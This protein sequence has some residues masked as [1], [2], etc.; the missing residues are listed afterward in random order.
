[1]MGHVSAPTDPC[2]P[3]DPSNN[4]DPCD[5]LTHDSPTHRLPWEGLL[6]YWSTH[7]NTLSITA[8]ISLQL[9]FPILE[10]QTITVTIDDSTVSVCFGFFFVYGNLRYLR[11]TFPP[12]ITPSP[13]GNPRGS[14]RVS[15]RIVGRIGSGVRVSVSFASIMLLHS[16]GDYVRTLAG[17]YPLEKS[18][19]RIPE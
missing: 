19:P 2:D 14:V 7:G 8:P 15:S 13:R 5:L 3:C 12:D 17:H 10:R 4:G 6:D 11:T 1:M 9:P 16:A 18:P